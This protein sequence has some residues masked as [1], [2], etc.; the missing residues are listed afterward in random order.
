MENDIPRVF[1]ITDSGELEVKGYGYQIFQQF[2]D[3]HNITYRITNLNATRTITESVNMS[4]IVHEIGTGRTEISM[5]PYTGIGK[6]IG[7]MGYPIF[8]VQNCL[9]VPVR[10][11]IPRFMYILRPFRWQSWLLILIAVIYIAFILIWT[12]PLP[13]TNDKSWFSRQMRCF[14]E[15]LSFVLFR[16]ITFM[17]YAP[18]A[19]FLII[20]T[21][22]SVLGFFITTW[23]SDLLGSFLTTFLVGEQIDSFEDLIAANLP[24]LAKYYEKHLLLQHVPLHLLEQVKQL[25]VPVNANVQVAHLLSFNTSYSYYMTEERWIFLRLQQQYAARA[26]YR[27]S[28]ICFG[29]PCI[30]YP[31]R[32]DSHL[33]QPMTKFIMDVQSA[34]LDH[35]WL[36]A[37]FKYALYAGYVRLI[38]N[39]L[40]L[41]ALDLDSLRVAWLVIASGWLVALMA[42][43][44]EKVST[45]KIL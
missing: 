7:I 37:D 25:I 41:K 21:L 42:F 45:K 12:S 1:C 38:N 22:L 35:Y 20:F 29:M 31:M 30:S 23:Y 6:N 28:R 43:A 10:N 33:A 39:S 5:H 40:T 13:L 14:L 19:Q 11:E 24:I 9:I 36:T 34:G 17:V 3:R 32:L 44:I 18:R 2:M 16:P 8:K 27:W 4:Q 26:I 15:S